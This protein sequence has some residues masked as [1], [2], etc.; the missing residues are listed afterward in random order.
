MEFK[1]ISRDVINR[2]LRDK[3]AIYK[4]VR[5]DVSGYHEDRCTSGT[6]RN[7]RN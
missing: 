1:E 4:D 3:S 6:R 5:E 7:I 2:R